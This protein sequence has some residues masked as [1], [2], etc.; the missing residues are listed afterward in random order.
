M[1][2]LSYA[3]ICSTALVVTSFAP[4]EAD[5]YASCAFALIFGMLAALVKEK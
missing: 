1:K 2:A 5:R 4:N 3:L